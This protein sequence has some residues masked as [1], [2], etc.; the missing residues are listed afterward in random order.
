MDKGK[1]TQQDGGTCISS[2]TAELQFSACFNVHHAESKQV[3]GILQEKWACKV[4]VRTYY[5]LSESNTAGCSSGVLP[6]LE[7]KAK[8]GEGDLEL[9]LSK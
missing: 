2:N 7:V 1:A 6:Y 3:N 9:P 4:L 5:M 8:D